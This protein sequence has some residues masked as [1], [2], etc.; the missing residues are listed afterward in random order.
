M[1]LQF[2]AYVLVMLSW[3]VYSARIFIKKQQYKE[4]AIY[5][6]LMG[7]CVILGVLYIAHVRLPSTTIPARLMFGYI[8]RII[9]EH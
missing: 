5:S 6:S 3:T 1:I 7:L 4:T 2:A 8:G 9:L